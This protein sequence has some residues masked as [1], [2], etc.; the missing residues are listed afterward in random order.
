[1]LPYDAEKTAQ[2]WKRVQG[3]PPAV[4]D[5]PALLQ[6]ITEEWTDA[7]TDLHLSHHFRGKHS[8]ALRKMSWQEQAHCACLKGIYAM[9]TGTHPHVH[10]PSVPRQPIE[11]LL[12]HCYNRELQCVNSYQSRMHDSEHGASFAR[13]AAQEQ[14]HC[15]ILLQ[16]LGNMKTKG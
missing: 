11:Q 8:A 10:A 16:L 13:L 4:P 7:V 5:L 1:M 6:M 3:Q 14:E 15:H 12:R 9:L 2:I